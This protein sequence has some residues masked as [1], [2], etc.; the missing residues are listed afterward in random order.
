MTSKTLLLTA[1][2]LAL[3]PLAACGNLAS[4]GPRPVDLSYNQLSPLSLNVGQV[5]VNNMSPAG[6]TNNP[7]L[8]PSPALE[9]YARS[10]FQGNNMSDGILN[11][12]IEQATLKTAEG[13][14]SG[15]WTDAF[16][17]SKPVEYTVTMRVGLD[18]QGRANQPGVKSAYTLER[19]KTLKEG[20]SLA[21]RDRE[22]SELISGMIRDLDTTLQNGISQNMHILQF[23]S[24]MSPPVSPVRAAPSAPQPLA[25]GVVAN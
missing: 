3:V 8:E 5:Q 23:A 9:R 16:S 2:V 20:V 7:S 19:K 10:R 21:D 18:L 4:T 13:T 14:G 25:T 17:L 24:P 6:K 15:N 11:V 1:A 22:V 12:N